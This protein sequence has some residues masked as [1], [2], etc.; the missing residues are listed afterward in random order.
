MDK[1]KV[2]VLLKFLNAERLDVVK[3]VLEDDIISLRAAVYGIVEHPDAVEPSKESLAL[4]EIR[5]LLRAIF[6]SNLNDDLEQLTSKLKKTYVLYANQFGGHRKWLEKAVNTCCASRY[7]DKDTLERVSEKIRS[8]KTLQF[9]QRGQ[10]RRAAISVVV[11]K[12]VELTLPSEEFKKN[13]EQKL[14]ILE[15]KYEQTIKGFRAKALRKFIRL[16][17]EEME[18]IGDGCLFKD[19]EA[20]RKTL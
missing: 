11:N 12:Y 17:F 14:K 18:L 8:F 19:H 20:L 9:S 5:E 7:V 15:G 13:K 1:V 16:L 6:N 2:N 10:R 3:P 4:E